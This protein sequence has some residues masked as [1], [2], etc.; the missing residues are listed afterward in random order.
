MSGFGQRLHRLA[1][2][3][4][5]KVPS[6]AVGTASAVQTVGDLGYRLLTAAYWVVL[7]RTLEKS[8]VGDIAFA[9]AIS[10]PVAVFVDAGF[11]LY[12]VR[13]Y[14]IDG[15]RGLPI[16]LKRALKARYLWIVGA[17][18]S[19]AG[20]VVTLGDT[21]ERTW[22]GP[23]IALSYGFDSSTQLW[24]TRARA[25]L[26]MW[27]DLLVRM[28][29]GGGVTLLVALFWL[30]GALDPI[31]VAIASASVYGLVAVLAFARW[32]TGKVWNTDPASEQ[33]RH[34]RRQFGLS[35][36][37]ITAYSRADAVIIQI[38]LGSQALANYTLAFKLIEALRVIPG[39]IARA[40]LAGASRGAPSPREAPTRVSMPRL[41]KVSLGLGLAAGAFIFVAGPYVQASLFG[42]SYADETVAVVRLLSVTVAITG[43]TA[44]MSALLLARGSGNLV[45]RNAAWTLGVTIG[46]AIPAAFLADITGVAAAVLVG[47]L[48]SVALY[49]R[50]SV[51]LK[52]PASI[53]GV[54]W[55]GLLLVVVTCP[56]VIDS[57]GVVS[58]LVGLAVSSVIVRATLLSSSKLP[59]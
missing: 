27:P 42:R 36:G 56:L 19:S 18:V 35:A 4:F 22:I 30:I 32:R 44:P 41:V 45:V 48:V 15:S 43:F 34:G 33:S 8:A 1:L 29:Q 31:T 6:G 40:A 7:S 13:E 59:A 5:A 25:N 14:R 20:V 53:S 54:R 17:V 3:L 50:S 38:V 47:E 9:N 39:A 26:N 52:P 46:L 51:R 12:L 37:L 10:A 57:S 28:S 11:G 24:L 21:P 16:N 23:L 49:V 2:I 55:A 58:L